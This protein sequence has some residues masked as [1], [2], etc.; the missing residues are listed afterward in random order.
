[1]FIALAIEDTSLPVIHSS[2]LN[3]NAYL[4]GYIL[5]DESLFIKSF[6]T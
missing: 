4:R 3:S 6:T 2:T 1:M 5:N